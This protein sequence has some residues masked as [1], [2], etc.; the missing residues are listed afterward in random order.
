MQKKSDVINILLLCVAVPVLVI[1][2]FFLSGG[3][4]YYLV[5]ALILVLAMVPFFI[6]FEK[7]NK[8]AREIVVLASLTALAVVSR[9]AFY[10]LPQVKPIAAVVIIAAVSFG[11]EVGFLVGALSMFLSNMLFGQGVWT[12]FQMVAL[13]MVGLLCGLL[14]SSSKYKSNRWIVGITGGLITF[15][16]YGFIV[17]TH[18]VLMMVSEYSLAS[19]S[20]VYL[21]GVPLN[22]V[23]GATTAAVL[24]LFGKAFCEKLDRL[25]RKYGIFGKDRS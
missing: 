21:A 8:A 17:D 20:A 16:V 1:T 14:F 6:S 10:M 22:F 11:Y 24:I 3:T 19:V 4:R 18:S 12:P 7:K 23:F 9:A 2:A 15:F 25:K 5:S 13:G